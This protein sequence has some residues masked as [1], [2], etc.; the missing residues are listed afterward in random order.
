MAAD[1]I[2]RWR[3]PDS[4]GTDGTDAVCF[5]PSQ[6]SDF[7]AVLFGEFFPFALLAI[8]DLSTGV[9]CAAPVKQ[10]TGIDARLV[11]RQVAGEKEN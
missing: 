3:V 4:Y 8:D 2:P 11:L 10:T 5:A 7:Q 6:T 1:C 9:L